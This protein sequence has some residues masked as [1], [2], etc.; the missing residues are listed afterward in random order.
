MSQ[1]EGKKP[2]TKDEEKPKTDEEKKKEKEAEQEA[3]KAQVDAILDSSRPKNLS[4]GVKSGLSNVVAGAVGGVG[5]IVLAPTI[6]CA[7]GA[8]QAGIVGGTV[9][10]V[11]GALVGT[12]GGAALMVGGAVQGVMQMGRGVI[13]IPS[14][15][16][17]P[18]KGKWW[19]E[20][21]G[22]WIETNLEDEAKLLESIP[23]NDDDILK[24]LKEEEE[25]DAGEGG[26][27]GDVVDTYY[28]DILEVEPDAPQG[29][30]KKKYYMLARK[31]HP[32]KVGKDDKEAAD[33]FKDIAEAYQVL[34]DPELRAKYDKDGR[35]GLSADKT[36]TVDDIQKVDPALL[37]AF[38]FGSDKFNDYV[39]RLAMATSASIGDSP[40]ITP[41]DARKLQRRRCTRLAILLAERLK[42]WTQEDYD[43][44][45]TTWK[46]EAED[47]S[48]ASYGWHMVQTIGKVYCISAV[49]FLGSLDSGIGMPGISKWAK[50][51]QANMQYSNQKTKGKMDTL[52]GGMK[53]MET[54]NK[55]EAEKKKATT[56]EEKQQ[57]EKKHEKEIHEALLN[58]MWTTTVVDI[59]ATIHETVQM[60]L[61]DKAVDKETRKRRAHG[62]KKLGEVFMETPEVKQEGE[63][64]DAKKMYEDAAFAAMLETIQRKDAA[65]HSASIKASAKR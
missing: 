9:G 58:V 38:L 46:T 48:K 59:T 34:S 3:A 61:F 18:R 13:A 49:Q 20:T 65:A 6:G 24:D 11:G 33:K 37:F 62:L 53:M 28:Y 39:G 31:Y 7:A 32:D 63:E 64:K 2:E 40:K 25:K 23:K 30:I 5:V 36:E 22:K 55:M 15:V 29:Q 60:V 42:I 47:L 1:K 41:Q 27:S 16:M 12:V 51:H 44:A 19:N 21:E 14:S 35:G 26:G 45:T 50:G 54:A 10:L 17:E 56:E 52:K 8:K 4:G 57:V 43:L